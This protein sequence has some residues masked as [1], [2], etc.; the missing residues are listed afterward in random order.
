MR[1]NNGTHFDNI[2]KSFS[3]TLF[4]HFDRRQLPV[5]LFEYSASHKLVYFCFFPQ[6]INGSLNEQGFKHFWK[7]DIYPVSPVMLAILAFCYCLN[8]QK[9]LEN[10]V[11]SVFSQDTMINI[12]LH[13]NKLNRYLFPI[14]LP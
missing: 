10:S 9:M 5:E 13:W 6:F 3:V 11:T 14:Y 1:N 8:F 4:R 12:N 7:T 2:N